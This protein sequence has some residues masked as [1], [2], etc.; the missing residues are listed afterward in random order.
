MTQSF[1]FMCCFFYI[2]LIKKTNN[3]DPGG[4]KGKEKRAMADNLLILQV[5][6]GNL[7]INYTHRKNDN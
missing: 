6:T 5:T 4:F 1:V 7:A 3:F 2:K